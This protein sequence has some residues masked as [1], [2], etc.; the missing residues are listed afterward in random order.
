MV[1]LIH[2]TLDDYIAEAYLQIA[3]KVLNRDGVGD[4]GDGRWGQPPLPQKLPVDR[5]EPEEPSEGEQ[6]W[7]LARGKS[8]T[9]P[10]HL[11][12]VAR[13]E[14]RE[15]DG[16][17]AFEDVL[18]HLAW[19]RLPVREGR[20]AGEEFEDKDAKRPDVSALVV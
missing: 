13:D 12:G 2:S 6:R 15:G 5:G 4:P 17:E 20:S 18:V 19:H 3:I 14:L 1:I 9:A 10:D 11:G 16:A 7:A 8:A